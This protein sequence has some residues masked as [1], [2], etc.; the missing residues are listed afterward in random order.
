LLDRG[1]GR[2]GQS[3]ELYG[4]ESAIE[5]DEVSALEVIESRLAALRERSLAMAILS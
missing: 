2:P 3:V 1:Y 4:G 5:H